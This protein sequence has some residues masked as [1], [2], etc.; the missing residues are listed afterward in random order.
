LIAHHAVTGDGQALRL[1]DLVS[2]RE[3]RRREL[4]RLVYRPLEINY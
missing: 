4:H 1:S 3:L 2:M